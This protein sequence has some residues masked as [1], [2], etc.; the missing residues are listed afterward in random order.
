MDFIEDRDMYDVTEDDIIDFEESDPVY[1][2]IKNEDGEDFEIKVADNK[3]EMFEVAMMTESYER[4]KDES[5]LDL[6]LEY[7]SR[8]EKKLRIIGYKALEMSL[9]EEEMKKKRIINKKIKKDK[10]KMIKK[11]KR[12]NRKK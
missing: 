8:E 9:D 1:V 11:S 12:K 2:S 7:L 4:T 10:R 3:M 5:V 6:Y